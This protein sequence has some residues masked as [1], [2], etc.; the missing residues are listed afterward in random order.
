MKDQDYSPTEFFGSDLVDMDWG[1]RVVDAELS[2]HCWSRNEAT[3][4][5]SHARRGIAI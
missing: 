3:V 4:A 1:I 5:D 2:L